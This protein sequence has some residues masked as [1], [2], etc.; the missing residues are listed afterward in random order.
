M[1]GQKR[2]TKTLRVALGLP[3]IS[4]MAAAVIQSTVGAHHP[5]GPH[6]GANHVGSHGTIGRLSITSGKYPRV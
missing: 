6:L 3:L 1:H 4:L 2:L 5:P